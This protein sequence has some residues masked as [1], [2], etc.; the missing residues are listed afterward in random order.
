[1][2][3]VCILS[4]VN[5]KHMSLITLYTEKLKEN[6]IDF[7]IIYMDK[8][9]EREEIDA[10]SIYVYKNI[11]DSKKNKIRKGLQY[12]KFRRFAIPILEK[13][14][15]D[16]I[17]VW[18]DIAI[19]MFAD[20]LAKRWPGKYSL[21]IRDYA[22]HDHYLFR[23]RYEKVIGKSAFTTI[24][25]NGFKE[26]L[27]PHNYIHVHSYNSEIFNWKS[28]C[29][30][31]K[32]NE[33]L[34]ISFIGNVRFFEIN[35]KLL[36]VFRNDKRFILTYFGINAKVLEEY[37]KEKRIFNTEF[38]DE[39][40]VQKTSEY[41]KR[42]D[43]VNNIYGDSDKNLDYA[44]SIKLYHG[45]FSGA[46]IL[47]SKNTY[48]GKMVEE[49]GIGVAIDKIDENLP[50]TLYNWYENIDVKEFNDNIKNFKNKIK[51]DNKSFEIMF[52]KYIL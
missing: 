41:I 36:D 28:Q 30:F 38:I 18:N 17:I 14:E 25:S 50:N 44:V 35:K 6:N 39:F 47:A 4:A 46:P 21:N 16:F 19:F 51:E 43:L 26:F 23:N 34:K 42:M 49:L 33:A 32:K 52:N 9:G 13:N 31:A 2:K 10:K 22:K 20:Y 12:L 7:D 40:P 11:I 29:L 24:S 8:Y 27:P 3:K 45:V 37:A 48:S 5:I 1:M 15:Y